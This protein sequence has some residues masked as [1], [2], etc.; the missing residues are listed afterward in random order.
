MGGTSVASLSSLTASCGATVYY[1]DV[2]RTGAY[3][4]VGSSG[5]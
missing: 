4:T 3:A 5:N 1:T 2:Y